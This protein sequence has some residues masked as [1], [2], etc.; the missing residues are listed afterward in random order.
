M[1]DPR[2]PLLIGGASLLAAGVVLYLT[3]VLHGAAIWLVLAG[4]LM[5]AL[6]FVLART[7]K[8]TGGRDAQ[9]ML[10]EEGNTTMLDDPSRDSK[11]G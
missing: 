1:K 7:A 8:A 4:G 3:G 6:Y 5:T 2:R 11:D 10:Y 9:S